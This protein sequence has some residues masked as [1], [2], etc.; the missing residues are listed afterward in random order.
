MPKKVLFSGIDNLIL[1]LYIDKKGRP[2]NM[3]SPTNQL[4]LIPLTCFLLGMSVSAFADNQIIHEDAED[5]NT[6][7]WSVK[8]KHHAG[9]ISNVIDPDNSGNRVIQLEAGKKDKTFKFDF[10]ES[11]YFKLQW[12]MKFSEPV[13]IEIE[14]RTNKGERTIKYYAGDN[15]HSKC[16]TDGHNLGSEILNGKWTIILRDL[17]HDLDQKRGHHRT[18]IIA[19][20]SIT[21]TGSGYI[22]DIISREY[23]DADHDLIPDAVEADAGLN[24]NN[25]SDA[26]EDLDQD[27]ISNLDEFILGTSISSADTDSDSLTDYFEL[28]LSYT[29]PLLPDSDENGVSDAEEDFDSDSLNNLQEQTAGMNPLFPA[30]KDDVYNYYMVEKTDREDAESGNTD[31]WIMKGDKKGKKIKN[32]IDPDNADN[33]VIYFKDNSSEPARLIFEEPELT[34]F[35]IQWDM[36]LRSPYIIIIPC[37]TTEGEKYLYYT[38]AKRNWRGNHKYIHHGLGNRKKRD[39]R[40]TV[41]RD[42][43]QDIWDAQPDC[44]LLSVNGFYVV[45]KGIIDNIITLAYADADH[46][47]IPDSIEDAAGLNKNDSSDALK[48][49]DNDGVNNLEEFYAGTLE[50]NL[51]DEDRDGLDDDWERKYFGDLSHGANEDFDG[52][53]L[54][55]LEEQN[56]GTDP[57]KKDTDGDGMSD[58][59]ELDAGMDPLNPDED[60]DGLPDGWE[61]KYFGNMKQT[62]EGDPDNDTVNNITEFKYGRHPNAGV[63][64]DT[65]NKI[66]LR[67]NMP[68]Q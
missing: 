33:R 62:A 42:L 47:L 51:N 30:E 27:N 55:N 59:D 10:S 11:P 52:D 32:I 12:K 44:K 35:K 39:E 16:G 40:V 65:E 66:K 68:L 29:S 7:G 63:K 53:G 4:K 64:Q 57:T 25:P 67:L 43:Q 24:P 45:G 9:T 26:K 2:K 21:I 50:A 38:G 1:R 18:R 15:S 28:Y 60:K 34:Q 61:M 23:P 48:D 31:K 58:K 8:G 41:H 46:D 37:T 49:I 56:A 36:E 5:G 14:C 17:E 6:A 13:V 20:N 19:V 3:K 22:D 54:S